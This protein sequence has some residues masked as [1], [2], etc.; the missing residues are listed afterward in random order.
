MKSLFCV[1]VIGCASIAAQGA[2]KGLSVGVAL[3]QQSYLI[4]DRVSITASLKNIEEEPFTIYKL[5]LWGYRGGL[6]L[7]IDDA[8]GHKVEPEQN[9]DDSVIPS[10]LADPASFLDLLPDYCWGVVR[11]DTAKNLFRKPGGYVVRVRYRSPVPKK[12]FAKS[13]QWPTEDGW[14]ESA[15]VKVDI[16]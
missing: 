14:V 2:G 11:H 10:P 5:L 13:P 3:D 12:Y 4:S 16:K 7:E 15:P 8:S 1:V 6:V 9:D